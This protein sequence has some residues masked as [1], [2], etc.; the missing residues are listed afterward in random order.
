MSTGNRRRKRLF[1]KVNVAVDM[2]LAEAVVALALAA[3]AELQI[4][5]LL[6]GTAADRALVAV[7]VGLLLAADPLRLTLE[8]DGLCLRGRTSARESAAQITPAEKQEVQNCDHRQK[9]K[10]Q[11][12]HIMRLGK[13][14]EITGKI[15]SKE[16]GIHHSQPFHFHRNHKKQQNLQVRE[17]HGKREE[18][19]KVDILRIQRHACP[20]DEIRKK[21]VDFR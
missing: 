17:H 15:I 20:G 6:V 12:C 11:V 14:H 8:V 1:F 9:G 7:K 16:G 21:A 2:V 5:I 18:H 3:V 4:G 19:G 13:H 10:D